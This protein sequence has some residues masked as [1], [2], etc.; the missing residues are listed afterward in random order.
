MSHITV[1]ELALWQRAGFAHTLL[2]V[3]RAA[4][5][6]AEGSEIAGASW[7]DPAAWLEW[8]DQVATQRP[9]VLYCV[10][11]HE[12]SQGLAAALRAMDI[13]ARH[14]V[15]GFAAWQAAGEAVRGIE[16]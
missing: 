13:D 1:Q 6:A 11:G 9:A 12:V 2:D 16:E 15:G 3:R 8:K 4:A 5:R 7:A 10:H 14:L